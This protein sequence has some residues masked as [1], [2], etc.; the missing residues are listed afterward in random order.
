MVV[1]EFGWVREQS[2]LYMARVLTIEVLTNQRELQM[3]SKSVSAS[4]I[5]F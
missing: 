3:E 1:R 4:C 2:C 5:R